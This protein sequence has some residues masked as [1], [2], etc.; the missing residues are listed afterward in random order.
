[1]VAAPSNNSPLRAKFPMS[2]HLRV[3][4]HPMMEFHHEPQAKDVP[5]TNLEMAEWHVHE[6]S[7]TSPIMAVGE[8]PSFALRA[9]SP[10]EAGS[11]IAP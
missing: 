1:M 8:D 10:P 9:L 6:G 2:Q 3:S 7:A 11:G 4:G 5:E